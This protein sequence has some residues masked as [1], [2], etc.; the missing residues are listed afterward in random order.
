M[1]TLLPIFVCLCVLWV[2]NGAPGASAQEPSPSPTADVLSSSPTPESMPTPL[3]VRPPAIVA[4]PGI[5]PTGL[6]WSLDRVSE[7]F[8]RNMFSFGI[9]TLR[10][11]V[12]LTQAAERIAEL[13]GLERAGTL[14]AASARSLLASQEYLLRIADRL[15]ARQLVRGTVPSD[16]LLLSSRTRLAAADVLEELQEERAVWRELD[17]ESFASLAPSDGEREEPLT[18]AEEEE[19]ALTT[20]LDDTIE[21]LVEFEDAVLPPHAPAPVVRLLAEQKIAKAE[22]DLLHAVRT[23][24]ERVAFGKILVAD[25]E[26]RAA[27]EAA[28]R[29][30]RQLY[31]EGNVGEALRLAKD[32]R[33]ISRQLK[34]G[35]I[36][37]TPQSLHAA[38]AEQH[39]ERITQRFVE[40]GAL[41][42]DAQQAALRRARQT[43]EQ[44]RA[45][46][47][48]TSQG[49]SGDHDQRNDETSDST[50]AGES[51]EE[52]TVSVRSDTGS[53]G[54][55][56]SGSGSDSSGTSGS[57]GSG[58]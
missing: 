48:V 34:S 4:E 5:L 22:R 15:L 8:E 52:D 38:N 39:I 2:Q 56:S 30:A 43:I 9:P 58:R 16:V 23:T 36:A 31:A 17:E 21:R 47:P 29:T 51:E 49:M 19:T 3:P 25:Q 24:E 28:L 11:R 33:Q 26:L 18:P 44:V 20:L 27:A 13:Q 32:A 37:L 42:V 41:T 1:K 46:V 12:A 10:A 7:F 35:Q 53:S 40:Q 45:T 54:S 50:D 57:S 55:G 6:F 14:T